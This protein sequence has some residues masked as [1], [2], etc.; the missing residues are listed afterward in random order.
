[1]PT[2][3]ALH[4]YPLAGGQAADMQ[5]VSAQ[6]GVFGYDRWFMLYDPANLDA[7]N[8][9]PSRVGQ[10]HNSAL[11]RVAL[12]DTG[13]E[14]LPT[15]TVDGK[16]FEV[17]TVD[18]LESGIP[19]TN[20]RISDMGDPA[21]VTDMGDEASEAFS[22]LLNSP[23]LRLA[24]RD[25]GQL[26]DPLHPE[27]IPPEDRRN[28]V[29]HFTFTSTLNDLHSRGLRSSVA[30]DRFRSNVE[31]SDTEPWAEL[32]W[33]GKTALS[34]GGVLIHFVRPTVRCN[35]TGTDQLTGAFHN[36]SRYLLDVAR[37]PVE[38]TLRSGR[39]AT[40]QLPIK[41]LYG[42]IEPAEGQEDAELCVSDTFEIID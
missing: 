12:V 40:L 36:D 19:P 31:V 7:H 35:V 32:G 23:G 26:I 1:M 15:F 39:T 34:N 33:I 14:G 5:V 10:K 20:L 22:N 4:E 24:R 6:H 38:T 28:A 25:Y 17:F 30:M 11:A 21:R 27:Y 8:N 2:I 3:E 18:P 37:S 16:P 41:G 29:V 13:E 9:L 42:Y